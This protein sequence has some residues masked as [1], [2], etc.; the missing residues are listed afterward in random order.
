MGKDPQDD[1]QS[2]E[3]ARAVSVFRARRVCSVGQYRPSRNLRWLTLPG[4]SIRLESRLIL[5]RTQ[6]FNRPGTYFFCLRGEKLLSHN[7]RSLQVWFHRRRA[8]KRVELLYSASNLVS[9]SKL[10]M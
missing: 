8:G 2:Y 9:D 1:R 4:I 3:S 6:V 7:T 10:P 5:T